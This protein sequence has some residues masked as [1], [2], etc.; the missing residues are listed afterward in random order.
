M[1]PYVRHVEQIQR[2]A[3][4]GRSLPLGGLAPAPIRSASKHAS[5]AILFSPH[6]D[7]E[8]IVGGLALRLLREAGWRILTVP[9]TLGSRRDRR[10]ERLEELKA[11]C[12]SLGFELVQTRAILEN[13]REETR[14]NST[15][16]W[17]EAVSEIAALIHQH[18][19]RLVFFPHENDVNQTHVGVHLL[20]MDAL[21]SLGSEASLLVAETEYWG[22]MSAPNLMVESNVQDVA[23]LMAA[24]SCHVGEVSRNPYH[25][26]LPAWMQDNVRVGT[27]LVGGQGSAAPPFSFATLYR[28][29]AWKKGRLVSCLAENI[30]LGCGDSLEKLVSLKS[31]P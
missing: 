5:V 23:D 17:P 13:I 4:E 3:Q 18:R 15:G 10:A 1:N 21:K 6:P 24:L 8:C 26:G 11:A 7:D 30:A 12:A 28:L 29:R 9:V 14:L 25:L 20:L 27:E 19:P 16:F 22:R 31:S 2:L